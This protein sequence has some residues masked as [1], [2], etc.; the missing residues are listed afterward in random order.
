M[1]IMTDTMKI[2]AAVQ[3]HRVRKYG[4]WT[5]ALI[6]L[7]AVLGFL[8]LP[9]IVRHVA[10]GQLSE[11]LHRPVTIR[12]VAINP[13]A[14][15]LAVE[16]L[17]IKEREG[18]E[19]FAGFESL[20]LNLQASSLFRWGP[21]IDEIRL[22]D[23]KFHVVRSAGSRYNFSDLVDE[24][25]AEP[26]EKEKKKEEG[27]E[28]KA[29]PAFSLNNIQVFGGKIEFDDRVV[30]EKHQ[31]GNISLALPFISSM[32]YATDVFV[33]PH[34]SATLNGAP[35]DV[36]GKSKPFAE[37]RES[38]FLLALGGVQLPKYFDYSPVNL[39][40]KLESGTLD[41]DLT[42]LFSYQ[43]GEMPRLVVSGKVSVENLK[44]TE[45][46]GQPLVAF[47]RLDVAIGSA[48]LSKGRF[49]IDRVALDSP[50]IAARVSKEGRINWLD[51]LPQAADSGQ[52]GEQASTPAEWSLGE[53]KLVGGTLRWSDESN[54]RTFQAEI[55]AIDALVKNL[56][57]Q[58]SV[59]DFEAAWKVDGGESLKV[60]A[61][62]VKDGKLDLAKRRVEIGDASLKGARALIKRSADGNIEWIEP[63]A[64]RPAATAQEEVSAPWT[65]EIAKYI[66]EEVG[67]RFEDSSVSP[68][69]VQSIENLGLELS[70]VSSEPGRAAE[71]KAAFKFNRKGEVTVDGK[72]SAVP[73]DADLNLNVKTVDLL[74]LQ[75][76]FSE[77]LNI[78]IKRG[79]VTLGGKARLRQLV[80]EKGGQDGVGGEA[81]ALSGG[82]AG[83]VTLGDFQAVDKLNSSEFLRW[84]SFHFGGIDA[85][86]G[87]ESVSVGEV[88]LS[89]FFAR[90]IVSPEGKLNLLEIVRS[91][92]NA[93]ADSATSAEAPATTPA[94]PAV[95][96]PEGKAT[97]PVA[98]E[99]VPVRIE[100][101]TLQGGS[102][103]FTDNFVKPN[104]T[105]NLQQIGGRVTGLSSEPGSQAS[106]ELRGSYDK[107]APLN[108][109]A[110]INPLSAKPYLDLQADVKDIEL[111]S[112][113]TYA[114]KYAGYAI[115]KGKLSLSVKYKIENDQLEAENQ[116][117]LDQLDF[118]Q[119]VESPDATSLPVRLA[120]SLLKNRNGEINL[121]L[122]VS[123]SLND[124]QFSIGGVIVEMIVN[125]LVK[126]AT[127]PF[128]LI[129]SMFGDGGELADVEFDS[130]RATLTPEAVKRLENL[131]R[132]LTDRPAL[133]F[134]IEGR[135]DPEQDIEG[136]KRA[137]I[138]RKIRALKREDARK[139]NEESGAEAT[140][141]TDIT[142]AMAGLDQQ[143]YAALLERVYA[144]ENFPKPRNMV[145]LVKSLP[146]EEMEKLI[147]ANSTV[148]ADDLKGLAD[149]R[150]KAVRDWLI[151][152]EVLAERVFLLPGKV[153]AAS[154]GKS[155]RR[156]DFS[157][158]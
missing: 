77:K 67:I 102:V 150:A 133:K 34:F 90:V 113:S 63:P 127:S 103:R 27:K 58:G 16:G 123:G 96:S 48:D 78:D 82:F 70:N 29:A 73:L 97:A 98:V 118:G 126:A 139:Q 92:E 115:D 11:A 46:A 87:P 112:L 151:A 31:V 19:S 153:E 146:V 155:G 116:V 24:F 144:A 79:H 136:L 4:L 83:Q 68:K 158:K 140:A 152:H 125:L 91:D 99:S 147:L 59:A 105:A 119:A 84:K 8:A 128:A 86:I 17:D 66:A 101:I 62:A 56:D 94:E 10:V 72:L 129:G 142:N 14:L 148:D 89:D 93:D 55:S 81:L 47:K 154:E 7:F 120:V 52:P 117:F 36:K 57:G 1:N 61:F 15:S 95:E 157:L 138:E 114:E 156:A 30:G 9:P 132:A 3:S 110:R 74:P 76:Y 20:Y 32:D 50:E 65:V 137:R 28:K 21:V 88:A 85:R 49:V 100:K 143:D 38:E 141:A 44:A 134:E 51:L 60:D 25:M 135:A 124:P 18:D 12:S 33:E 53:A 41:T 149:R 2:R 71:V 5:V 23:P 107:V 108:I 109:S 145:G 104:Y 40:V 69:G 54:A 35:L 64:L 131:S 130:G 45:S 111:T 37:F 122:P 13:F 22:V 75:A 80:D 6:A 43:A 39:S 42:L 121:K 106:L 26:K